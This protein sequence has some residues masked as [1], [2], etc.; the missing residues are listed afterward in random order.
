MGPQLEIFYN[1]F[2]DERNDSPLK[3]LWKRISEEMQFCVQCIS[4]HHQAQEMYSL[5]YDMGTVG[6]LLNVLQSLDEER[7]TQHLRHINARLACQ[8]YNP[9]SDYNEVVAVMYEVVS[10]DLHLSFHILYMHS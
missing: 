9:Q 4:Q 5:E 8:E 7:V 1:Y 3:L 2:K 6:H 10:Y